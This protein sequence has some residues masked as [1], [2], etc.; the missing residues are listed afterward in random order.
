MSDILFKN[1]CTN[2]RSHMSKNN[3]TTS[4]IGIKSGLSGV[5][6]RR[7]LNGYA[8]NPTLSTIYKISEA[9]N[10]SII[11]LLGLERLEN[12]THDENKKFKLLNDI[13]IWLF[14]KNKQAG[15][16]LNFEIASEIYKGC[17]E[18]KGMIFDEILAEFIYK[19]YYDR[20]SD[21]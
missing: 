19:S 21:H 15:N 3:E 9:L 18:H 12:L 5:A 7:M 17:C 2:I 13:F 14:K 10:V 11:D 4:S 16:E 8:G 1:F 20:S 6:I